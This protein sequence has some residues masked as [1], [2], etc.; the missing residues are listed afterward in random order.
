MKAKQHVCFVHSSIEQCI[1]CKNMR[2]VFS[3]L[4][5]KGYLETH[6]RDHSLCISEPIQES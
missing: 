5:L 4:H 3:R 2:F 1:G 6:I